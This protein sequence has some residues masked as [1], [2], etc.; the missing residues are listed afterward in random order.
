MNLNTLP[1]G[2]WKSPLTPTSIARG[3]TI[4]DGIYNQDGSIVWL[5]NHSD[6]GV[7]MVQPADGQAI[8]ELN[9]G[10]SVR[11]RVG[12]GGGDFCVKDGEVFF[13]DAP[14]SRIFNQP[15]AAG[16]AKAITPAFGQASSPTLSQDGRWLLFVH[17]YEG[18]DCLAIVDREGNAYSQ[19]L[20][21]GKD[22]YMQPSWHPSGDRIAFIAWDH[23]NM[24]WDGTFLYIAELS[25]PQEN[26]LGELPV[27]VSTRLVDG[28]EKISVMQ[29]E[30]SPDGRFLAYI[31]DRSGWWQI[32]L[33]ELASGNCRQLTDTP[34]EHGFPAWIQ[35][36]RSYCFSPDSKRIYFI[37]NQNAFDSLW[38]LAVENGEETRLSVQEQYTN[39]SQIA[40]LPAS[41]IQNVDQLVCIASGAVTPTRLISLSNDGHTRVVRRSVS[42]EIPP[43]QFSSPQ[44]ITWSG[45]DG[46]VVYG[47][48]YPPAGKY[49]D[50]TVKP[51]LIL[52]VHGGPTSQARNAYSIQTQFFTT[53]GYAVL[54]LNHRGSTGYGRDYRNK[55]YGKWGVYDV[56]DGIA[57][58][59]HLSKQGLL[60]PNKLVIMGGSAGGFTVLKSLVDY[61][62]F[63]KAGICLYGI[64]N[65]FTLAADTHKFE[66][67]YS[68]FLLGRLPEA[69]SIY[70]ERS[71]I[72]FV[73]KI[74]DPIAF[75]QGEDDKVVPRSQ[76]DE[77]VLSLQ[78]R[79][80]PHIYHVYPGEG[81][82]FRRRE[83]MEHFYREVDRFLKQYVIY[84]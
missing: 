42:E 51:P 63:Y 38:Q 8:C 56:E 45:L 79:G 18:R 72:F 80:I 9:A 78:R 74:T 3:V 70:R 5:E 58:A 67:H 19:K 84:L 41:K 71:P 36:L 77:M 49:M 22:F 6:R 57:G 14:S 31:S 34:A 33:V 13:V 76:S 82:G 81:H 12:Y 59:R 39:F 47:L 50:E 4:V 62:G 54:E 83:T 68:D 60:E 55:L 43:S 2:L 15:I 53:R 21:A 37:R 48:F 64:S 23:P 24:P 27:A 46:E 35:G 16:A 26:R 61:P 30:F 32:Y 52:Y 11:A 66:A 29:P 69:V 40:A 28:G 25:I 1:Y 7:I 44:P 75:F 65:Q 73:E 17:S 10:H 20:A